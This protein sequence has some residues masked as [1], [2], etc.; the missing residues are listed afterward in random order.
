MFVTECF[1]GC[2]IAVLGRSGARARTWAMLRCYNATL[3]P[4]SCPHDD[5]HVLNLSTN[6]PG[7]KRQMTAAAIV[8]CHAYP[9]APGLRNQVTE[10]NRQ[11]QTLRALVDAHPQR[12]SNQGHSD[13]SSLGH[14]TQEPLKQEPPKSA[15]CIV[16]QITKRIEEYE[17]MKSRQAVIEQEAAAVLNNGAK[18]EAENKVLEQQHQNTEHARASLE[19][20]VRQTQSLL[21]NTVAS[22]N[23]NRVATLRSQ[24]PSTP[25]NPTRPHENIGE[26]LGLPALA[27]DL[28]GANNNLR[29]LVQDRR[30]LASDNTDLTSQVN[31]LT[32]AN[33]TIPAIRARNTALEEANT[34]LQ[35]L[36]QDYSR[37]THE[38]STQACEMGELSGYF[39][40]LHSILHA[41][42]P[43]ARDSGST[44]NGA[45]TSATS[46]TGDAKG[47]A[48]KTPA[49][50]SE[51]ASSVV[52]RV[53]HLVEQ[54]GTMSRKQ[55]AS[56]QE[57]SRL[58][59]DLMQH[60]D[61]T[62]GMEA[63]NEK[64]VYQAQE[65]HDVCAALVKLTY[66]ANDV[67]HDLLKSVCSTADDAGNG[68]D[69]LGGARTGVVNAHCQHQQ[70]PTSL[71][72]K[73]FSIDAY[74]LDERADT[75]L[76]RIGEP[77]KLPASQHDGLIMGQWEGEKVGL[78]DAVAVCSSFATD[79]ETL[80]VGWGHLTG[81]ND[82]HTHTIKALTEKA[83]A[84]QARSKLNMQEI[85]QM[86][87]RVVDDN[88][89][90]AGK[91]D[92]LSAQNNE[93]TAK[94]DTL[95][96]AQADLQATLVHMKTH[97]RSL[98][99]DLQQY[100]HRAGLLR[101]ASSTSADSALEHSTDDAAIAKHPTPATAGGA[102]DVRG[103]TGHHQLQDLQDCG[104][105]LGVAANLAGTT[106]PAT[107]HDISTHLQTLTNDHGH[108]VELSATQASQIS[109][110]N[111]Q[112]IDVQA[113]NEG[114]EEAF[115][116]MQTFLNDEIK[117]GRTRNSVLEKN[118]ADTHRMLVQMEKHTNA[119]VELL[120][121][122]DDGASQTDELQLQ[123]RHVHQ[124]PRPSTECVRATLTSS[125]PLTPTS[126]VSTDAGTQ[127]VITDER[128]ASRFGHMTGIIKAACDGVEALQ[129]TLVYQR[130]QQSK[131][132]QVHRGE[133][134]L[135]KRVALAQNEAVAACEGGLLELLKSCHPDDT[136]DAADPDEATRVRIGVVEAYV[137]DGVRML[138]PKLQTYVRSDCHCQAPSLTP[139]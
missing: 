130:H 12:Q 38:H 1:N 121:A 9:F 91:L 107:L 67:L 63:R 113:K 34:Q 75:L 117:H 92:A 65:M 23:A 5:R 119:L 134:E 50:N 106:L 81:D 123:Q 3:L 76:Q 16:V 125:P 84:E 6:L 62:S 83:Q 33:K 112:N 131:M 2:L 54:C 111:T 138:D 86:Y 42:N 48:Q 78:C 66:E 105:D 32:A 80:A 102:E 51:E 40:R 10:S 22:N 25:P 114:L 118:W 122:L 99:T 18:L 39:Q 90:Q 109:S 77:F 20:Q 82:A 52:T 7:D 69:G 96:A 108:L 53:G 45:A 129:H 14:D 115:T 57:M 116:S 4:V 94:T 136:R 24:M 55:A 120:G 61:A 128:S 110:L 19:A 133:L 126:S 98:G 127:P 21:Q 30:R 100:M 8:R 87:V 85:T 104:V 68:T 15:R 36:A 95:E 74:Q 101:V 60:R 11:F 64:L 49:C 56:Q 35:L 46:S 43:G 28:K 58:A 27:A 79:L 97:T 137:V 37:L 93:L 89:T 70:N 139:V 17:V 72:S 88:A 59:S 103:R 13:L 135:L 31:A 44:K 47:S 26:G 41:E 29:L 124:Q 132:K 71:V 73:T